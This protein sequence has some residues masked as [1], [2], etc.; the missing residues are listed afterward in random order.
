MYT[1]DCLLYQMHQ[2]VLYLFI[3]QCM[4]TI[5]TY[6][7]VWIRM[8]QWCIPSYAHMTQ[9]AN[10]PQFC[11]FIRFSMSSQKNSCDFVS[12]LIKHTRVCT[13]MCCNIQ[14]LICICTCVVYMQRRCSCLYA[15]HYYCSQSLQQVL[16]TANWNSLLCSAIQFYGSDSNSLQSVTPLI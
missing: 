7:C 3:L 13:C 8:Y 12:N 10:S 16:I 9:T 5:A 1:F 6:T 2:S 11:I 14:W 4:L 15:R